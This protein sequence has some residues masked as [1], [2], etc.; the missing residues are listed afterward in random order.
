MN[1]IVCIKQVPASNKV[2][3]DP[4]TGVMKRDGAQ[5]K[6]NPYDLFALETAF[7][8]REKL[9]GSVKVITMGPPQAAG[10]I[11][12][13][14]SM[15]ADEGWVLSD[16]KFAGADVLATSYTISQGIGKLGD[17]DIILCGKQTTDGDTAQVGPE[18]SERLGIPAIANVIEFTDIGE[19]SVT[20]RMDMGDSVQTAKIPYPCLV[21]VDKDIFMPRLPS[22]V[23]AKQTADRAVNILSFA[24]FA[25]QNEKHYGLAGSPTQVKRIFP[26]ESR[27]AAERFEGS[28]EQVSGSVYNKLAELKFI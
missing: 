11:R 28:A 16:R 3:V 19:K 12:E 2:G 9:G 27:G 23:K 7:R 6:M 25:D 8:I 1:I 26:P 15:G 21:C 22:Y 5:S 4:V 13:A 14:Y 18:I 17:Y 20:V 10:V 24:D